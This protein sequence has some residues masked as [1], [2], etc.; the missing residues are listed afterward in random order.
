VS[1]RLASAGVQAILLDVEGTTT[2]IAFVV[3]K[4]FPYARTHLRRHVEQHASAPDYARLLEQVHGEYA[5]DRESGQP[6]PAWGDAPAAKRLASVVAY[7]DW[8]MDRDRKST[9]LKDLQGRV[10]EEGY[11]LG[12]LQGDVFADVP[13]AFQRW[14]AHGLEIGIFSSGSILAQQLLFRHSSA[15]DLTGYL[16]WHFDTTIG[17]KADAESYR[18]IA[19]AMAI[20][21]HAVLFIS[22]VA[23]ELDAASAAGMQ[24]RLSIRPGNALPPDDQGHSVVRTFDDVA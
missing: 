11:R 20:P 8:L 21:P 7:L 3:E 2:P 22:D 9:S 14:R 1:V 10:W 4:L 12:E 23:L 5:R 6:V 15:G 18:R 19:A 24:T 17:G 16:R 13:R